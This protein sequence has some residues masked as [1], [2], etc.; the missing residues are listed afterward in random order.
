M[1]G[2]KYTA[3]S[4]YRYGFN[5]KEKDPETAGTS[6]YDYGF[7]IYNPALGRFLSV[8]PITKTYPMLT[9][10]QFASNT[11]IQAIDLDGLEAVTYVSNMY[12][13][14][15]GDVLIKISNINVNIQ[16]LNLSSTAD[17]DLRTNE[18]IRTVA[19]ETRSKFLGTTSANRKSHFTTEKGKVKQLKEP[20]NIKITYQVD[21]VNVTFDIL[22]NKSQIKN[23]APVLV[24]VDGYRSDKN[25][26]GVQ[27]GMAATVAAKYITQGTDPVVAGLLGTHEVFHTLG[28]EDNEGSGN[29]LMDGCGPRLSWRS[30]M[31]DNEIVNMLETITGPW[32]KIWTD[33]GKTK[34]GEDL[35]IELKAP[36]PNAGKSVD[37][38]V[39]KGI[40]QIKN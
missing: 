24:V 15:N 35:K 18:M 2:R 31:T 11:P 13:M 21:D 16:V 30:S 20:K 3:G 36:E 9:P 33:A 5:G 38:E 14:S 23:N 25:W 10:Y 28:A 19:A 40:I 29:G 8:D 37:I 27:F 32:Q 17:K 22:S 12:R 39:Q 7:R 6:T 4:G 1:P 34:K 26:A